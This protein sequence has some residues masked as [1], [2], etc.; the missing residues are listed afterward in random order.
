MDSSGGKTKA[1]GKENKMER[2]KPQSRGI[3]KE[4]CMKSEINESKSKALMVPNGGVTELEIK[5]CSGPSVLKLN[6]QDSNVGEI[7]VEKK[8]CGLP[9]FNANKDGKDPS[10]DGG[11]GGARMEGNNQ[12]PSQDINMQSDDA[13]MSSEENQGDGLPCKTQ[14]LNELHPLECKRCGARSFPS[15]IRGIAHSFKVDF[16]ALFETRC[17]GSKA[18]RIATLMG[19]P[20]FKIIDADGFKGGIWCLWSDKFRHVEVRGST[21]QFMHIRF[22]G[23]LG[24]VWEM[25]F[26]YGSPNIVLRRTLWRDLM[27]LRR[28]VH[29][30]WCLGGDFNATLASEERCS[31]R[32][33]GVR[34]ENS[35]AL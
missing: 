8:D 16:V 29:V 31:W 22:T 5:K 10:N 9:I 21:N 4:I 23:Q 17:S 7:I 27:N 20:N 13:I 30:P 32:S 6:N 34:I 24:Q 2:I 25:T 33:T 19:F 26:V 14:V 12:Y 18:D 3:G 11:S 1:R 28:A 35:A 15:L